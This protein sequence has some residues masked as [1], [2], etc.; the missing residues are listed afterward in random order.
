MGTSGGM[1]RVPCMVFTGL[2]KAWSTGASQDMA[3]SKPAVQ[4]LLED[5]VGQV[6]VQRVLLRHVVEHRV[7]GLGVVL[8]HPLHGAADA[9]AERGHR[10]ERERVEVVV[11]HH[12]ERVGPRR[13]EALAHPGDLGHAR[14]DLPAPVVAA[15]AL[16]V[17]GI[18][19][20]G[21]G[22]GE[23][24]LAHAGLLGERS[25]ADR[26]GRADR[27]QGARVL[28]PRCPA[29]RLGPPGGTPTW[30]RHSTTCSAPTWPASPTAAPTGTPSP[31]RASRA[32]SARSIASSAPAPPARPTPRSSRPQHFT[33]SVMFV[34]PGQGN[35]AA[36]P[37]GRGGLLHP[38]GQGA[39]LHRGRRRQP[40]RDGARPVG[41]RLLPGQRHPRL[42]QRGARA[43]V[44]PGDARQGQ[45][46]A[47]DLRRRRSAGPPRRAP[48][49]RG[50]PR[51]ALPVPAPTCWSA[52]RR[53]GRKTA[54]SSPATAATSTTCACRA[55]STLALVR[56]PHAHARVR[57]RRRAR[58]RA[59]WPASPRC[60][61]LD[62]LPELAAATVPP[63]V[64]EPESRP[65]SI[66][67]WRASGSR[68]VG[69]AV[70][71]VVADDPY[72]AA[73]GAE[74]VARRP[75][76]RCP[77]RLSPRR[78]LAPGAPRVNETWPDNL[79]AVTIERQGQSRGARWPGADV[80]VEPRAWP[81]RAWPGMPLETRGVLAA[82]DPIGGGLTV[83][84][85]TQVPFAVRSAIAAVL[86]LPEERIRVHRARRGRRLRRQGPRLSRGDPGA[87]G[88][89]APRAAGEVG[90]DAARALPHRRRRPRPGPRG[91]DRARSATAASWPSRPRSRAI[92]APR[93]TLGEAITLQHHQSPAR[94]LPRA[95]LPRASAA[96]SLTHKT[97]AAAYRGAGRPEAAFVL[98]RLLDRAARRI[99]M[100]PAELRRRNLIR[101]DEM[102]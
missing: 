64:P 21:H 17:V 99:G 30:P 71:V 95:E 65:T 60:W 76:S 81:I 52:P 38:R 36:H 39:G 4:S 25:V 20:V 75:T 69:E 45:A 96:T 11:G 89:A 72:V 7:E 15:G 56:S 40:R 67:S 91:A 8:L 84:T 32:S 10:V 55:C 2:R 1:G 100:D 79:V 22:A 57:A 101:P 54:A 86:G 83:W 77:P 33:L 58:R 34:P 13:G 82:P 63:L 26:S 46:R 28:R 18:E 48:P 62:D 88:G 53:S 97:F 78:P 43:R 9:H 59:R 92:T 41:L 49:R 85:S 51:L 42:H 12:D 61:T 87:R 3:R 68:H 6:L 23:D 102:P 90:R 70:A 74:R 24:D 44:S 66:P 29:T 5:L 94:A 14:D 16:V 98:D 93:P 19:H 73:D 80:V 50:H 35:A 27:T 37:R 31:T 47:H